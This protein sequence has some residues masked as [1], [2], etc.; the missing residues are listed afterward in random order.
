MRARAVLLMSSQSCSTENTQHIGGSKGECQGCATGGQNFSFSC[1]IW[2]KILPNNKV[3]AP[4]S[5]V[6]APLLGNPGSATVYIIPS[7]LK[8][9]F[10][11]Y[12]RYCQ[13]CVICENLDNVALYICRPFTQR[14]ISVNKVFRA[15]INRQPRCELPFEKLHGSGRSMI[16]TII[17]R[18]HINQP[19]CTFV[20]NFPPLCTKSTLLVVKQQ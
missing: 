12:V 5:G 2:Q 13:Y 11:R 20:R 15:N 17:F 7:R 6:G 4:I 9:K 19:C 8:H 10:D 14:S 18:V 3:F 16:F 1:C